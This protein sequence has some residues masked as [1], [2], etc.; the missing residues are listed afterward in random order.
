[1]VEDEGSSLKSRVLLSL[2]P[3][4]VA[5]P[6]SRRILLM[7]IVVREGESSTDSG[8]H[9]AGALSG[10]I[11]AVVLS[12]CSTNVT[13]NQIIDWGDALSGCLLVLLI[14]AYAEVIREYIVDGRELLVRAYVKWLGMNSDYP[15]GGRRSTCPEKLQCEVITEE[16]LYLLEEEEEVEDDPE[17]IIKRLEEENTARRKTAPE[18]GGVLY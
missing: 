2:F 1:M 17:V 16:Y 13:S 18:L 4:N 5:G 8:A 9:F 10:V 14:L 11:I 3:V 12:Y 7:L 15:E 6:H